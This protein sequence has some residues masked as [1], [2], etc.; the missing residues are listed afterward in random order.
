M[1][2]TTTAI[3]FISLSVGLGVCGWRFLK[4]FRKMNDSVGGGRIGFLLTLFFLGFTFQ[5]GG[6]LGLGTLFFAAVPGGLHV[7]AITA[8]AF[9]TLLAI[10]G[11]YTSYHIFSPRAAPW[12]AMIL[13]LLFGVIGVTLTIVTDLKPFITS[14]GGVEWNAMPP[15]SLIMFFLLLMSIGSQLYIF[16]RLFL[17]A[18]TREL[19][20]TSAIIAFIALGGV[21]T[22]FI[23]FI[24][25]RDGTATAFHSRVYDVATG[26]LG[27]I[28][29]VG[30]VVI[31]FI[32][33]RT[34][35]VSK[36]DRLVR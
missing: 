16:T 25:F 34:T 36:E 35:K 20:I 5:T 14:S 27:L 23:R 28:F 8:N 30:L 12:P 29:I 26:L 22:Q 19:K 4:A 13:V 7:V 24:L 18:G 2:V 10:L 1:I 33:S 15:L 3:A 9:L 32:R 17:Q 21:I 31:P 6:I 11:V